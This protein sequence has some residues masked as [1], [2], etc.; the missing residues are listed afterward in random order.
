M[1][2]KKVKAATETLW[3]T[4]KTLV[5]LDV[6]IAKHRLA[7]IEAAREQNVS[8]TMILSRLD[9]LNKTMDA[10]EMVRA[11]LASHHSLMEKSAIQLKVAFDGGREKDDP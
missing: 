7:L 5:D 8:D 10:L 11:C 4:E 6:S 3:D 1:I 2:S 9:C